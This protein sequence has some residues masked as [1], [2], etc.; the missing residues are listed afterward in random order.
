MRHF[1]WFIALFLFS[2]VLMMLVILVIVV[3][4]VFAHIMTLYGFLLF[5]PCSVY[6]ACV[7]HKERPLCFTTCTFALQKLS[8]RNLVSFNW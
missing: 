4:V 8:P 1:R 2:F 3:F 6:A 7:F 5:S